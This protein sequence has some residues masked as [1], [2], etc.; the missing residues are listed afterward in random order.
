MQSQFWALQKASGEGQNAKMPTV[1]WCPREAGSRYFFRSLERFRLTNMFQSILCAISSILMVD[2]NK[3][4]HLMAQNNRSSRCGRKF[5]LVALLS[6]LTEILLAI[7]TKK[8]TVFYPSQGA[9]TCSSRRA[10]SCNCW[11]LWISV[12][13][14]FP[15]DGSLLVGSVTKTIV[16]V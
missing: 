4:K 6:K 11:M 13:N 15:A 7:N 3:K 9:Q 12:A 16:S 1:R 5:L 2:Y 8:I 14:W 10:I